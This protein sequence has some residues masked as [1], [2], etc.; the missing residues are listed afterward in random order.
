MCFE[1]IAFIWRDAPEINVLSL[2]SSA[3]VY[4]VN[5]YNRSIENHY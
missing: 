1:V 2:T 5:V 3:Y 4:F